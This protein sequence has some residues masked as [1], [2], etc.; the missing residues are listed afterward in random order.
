MR[1]Q[2]PNMPPSAKRRVSKTETPP[3][4]RSLLKKA[5]TTHEGTPEPSART[6]SGMPSRKQSVGA[7]STVVWIRNPPSELPPVKEIPWMDKR[8]YGFFSQVEAVNNISVWSNMNIRIFD[9][10]L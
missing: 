6:P 10:E 3:T 7:T 8:V 5:K 9:V 4:S 2:F 1:F